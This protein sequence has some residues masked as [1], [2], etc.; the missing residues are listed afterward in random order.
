MGS[1]RNSNTTSCKGVLNASNYFFLYSNNKK[2]AGMFLPTFSCIFSSPKCFHGLF[3]LRSSLVSKSKYRHLDVTQRRGPVGD[4]DTGTAT[5]CCPYTG[6]RG[7]CWHPQ[8]PQIN[9]DPVF[10]PENK[11]AATREAGTWG[12]QFV[13]QHEVQEP[14]QVLFWEREQYTER[15]PAGL[16][17][18]IKFTLLNAGQDDLK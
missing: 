13:P 15:P 14:P 7:F 3:P 11:R 10:A 12:Q 5:P 8:P 4:G 16:S 6:D 9:S 17:P 2:L 18:R 1:R